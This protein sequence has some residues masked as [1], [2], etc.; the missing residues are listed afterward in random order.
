MDE[1]LNYNQV[2]V[3]GGGHGGRG[4]SGFLALQDFDV[5]LYNRTLSNVQPIINNGGLD[6]HGVVSGHASIPIVTDNMSKA[7]QGS[8]IVI[9]SVPAFAHKS[10]AYEVAPHLQTGQLILL[11]PGQTGGALEFARILESHVHIEDIILGEADSFSFISRTTSP[12]TVLISKIK[13]CPS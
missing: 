11:M 1:S 2:S 9:I 10:L 7:L 12:T 3:V 5:S 13:D 6:V 8:G 4:L